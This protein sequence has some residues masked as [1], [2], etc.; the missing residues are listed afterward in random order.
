[1]TNEYK[2]YRY[3][4]EIEQSLAKDYNEFYKYNV[5]EVYVYTAENGYFWC[6]KELP[7]AELVSKVTCETVG[8]CSWANFITWPRKYVDKDYEDY[9]QNSLQNIMNKLAEKSTSF[10]IIYYLY[11]LTNVALYNA[12]DLVN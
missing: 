6:A 5:K 8:F 9:T 7:E 10:F 11:N 2:I 4:W 1:M 3:L 12:T